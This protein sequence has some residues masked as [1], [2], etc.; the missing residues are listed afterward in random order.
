MSFLSLQRRETST[1]GRFMAQANRESCDDVRG[2]QGQSVRIGL[3]SFS[4]KFMSALM[5]LCLSGVA[6]AELAQNLSVD[7]R[8][9]SLGNAVT[10]DPPGISAIHFNPAGLSHV[11]G[12]QTDLQGLMLGLNIEREISAPPG[13]NIFGYSDDPVVCNMPASPV[14]G[15]GLCPDFKVGKSKV[16]SVSLYVPLLNKI[17]N[18]PAGLPVAIPFGAVAY[19]APESKI[20]YANG[21]YAP[22]AVGFSQE[23]GD[24]GNFMGEIVSLE[25]ITYL[26]PSA[27]YQV[28][29]N[30][31]LGASIG[32]SYAAVAM[33]TDLR[34]PNE[35]I[36]VLRLVDENICAP[37]KQ[38]SS[39][40]QIVNHH[41]THS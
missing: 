3:L 27:S 30:L 14:G 33:N 17:V 24:P 7:I 40:C 32:I 4:I 19:R 13:F 31:S 1:H 41:R 38:N 12:L 25:R 18:M 20:T 11:R 9:L 23:K 28:S 6:Q 10:A 15:N 29:D 2:D 16:K 36:G 8:S 34:L 5:G 39:S 37:F 22:L 21:F 26:S 35:L